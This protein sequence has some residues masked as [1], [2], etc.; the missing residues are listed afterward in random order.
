VGSTQERYTYVTT[1]KGHGRIETRTYY[2]CTDHDFLK[3]YRPSWKDLNG[4]GMMISKVEKNGVMTEEK[5]FH[6]N[7]SRQTA[8][9]I[10]T[11]TEGQTLKKEKSGQSS[12]RKSGPRRETSGPF[13]LK[14]DTNS[15]TIA[16]TS[17][18]NNGRRIYTV[19]ESGFLPDW[20]PAGQTG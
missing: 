9:A 19:C 2:L 6:M 18:E 15:F 8:G 11:G 1:E 16:N 14:R 20:L 10:P 17:S 4:I 7:W 12:A 5:H 3:I 13:L